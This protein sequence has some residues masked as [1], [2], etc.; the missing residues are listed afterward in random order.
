MNRSPASVLCAHT[1]SCWF[2]DDDV[3]ERAHKS[4]LRVR[5]IA[6]RG[7]RATTKAKHSHS[8][9]TNIIIIIVNRAHR[10]QRTFPRSPGLNVSGE[11]RSGGRLSDCVSAHDGELLSGSEKAITRRPRNRLVFVVG[12]DYKKSMTARWP[13]TDVLCPRL[14]NKQRSTMMEAR[15]CV[16]RSRWLAADLSL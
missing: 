2:N 8:G 5:E 12:G 6:R 3:A 16:D 11:P 14:R 15:C 13:P 7:C 10:G 4:N 9:T 1:Q